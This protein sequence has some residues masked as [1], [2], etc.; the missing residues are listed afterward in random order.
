MS[1]SYVT[2][3]GDSSQTRQAKRSFRARIS[4]QKKRLERQAQHKVLQHELTLIRTAAESPVRYDKMVQRFCDVNN[5]KL[6]S[7]KRSRVVIQLSQDFNLFNNPSKVLRDLLYLLYDAKVYQGYPTIRYI[8]KVCFGALYLVDNMCWEIANHRLWKVTLQNMPASEH[9]KFAKVR[10]FESSDYDTEAACMVN[11]RVH[12]NRKGDDLSNQSY[13]TKS[14]Q[15]RDMVAVAIAGAEDPNYEL[16]FDAAQAIDSAISEQFDNVIQ[17]VP[18]ANQASLC[19][20]YDKVTKELTI[21]IYNFGKTIAET[22]LPKNL[23]QPVRGEVEDIIRNHTKRFGFLIGSNFTQENAL[24]LL[25]LQEGI[26]SKLLTDDTRGHGL[27]DY[28]EK[29]FEL[30]PLCRIAIVSGRT[31]IK[32]DQKYPISLKNVLNRPRRILALNEDNDIYAKP[33][34]TYVRTMDV[35]FNGVIIETTIPLIY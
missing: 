34:K 20:F 6:W 3:K 13:R 24:T 1:K 31:A 12:I 14:K 35:A 7:K 28:I 17:H 25:A 26:S 4:I 18:N 11:E 19:A 5:M 2:Y 16:P 15:L 30:Q 21:L 33:D 9:V 22:L 8:D 27:I 29:C 23:P 10:S 32:I